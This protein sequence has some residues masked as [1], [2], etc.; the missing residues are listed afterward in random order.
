MEFTGAAVIWG[1]LA[2][3]A[4]RDCASSYQTDSECSSEK[5]I[6]RWRVMLVNNWNLTPNT[7]V[8][9]GPMP[10]EGEDEREEARLFHVGAMR[11]TQRLILGVG[12]DGGFGA[13]FKYESNV[14]W[15]GG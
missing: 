10:A 12:G 3:S 5:M 2:S 9:A 6:S 8:G 15:N 13:R 11:A 1:K 14:F 7:L 4:F